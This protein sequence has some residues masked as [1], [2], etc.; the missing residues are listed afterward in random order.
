MED[1]LVLH[2]GLREDA[3]RDTL[4][5]WTIGVGYNLSARGPAALET[6]IGRKFTVKDL[7]GRARYSTLHITREEALKALRLD[8]KR[9]TGAVAAAW[10]FYSQLDPVRQK[11]AVDMAF[12]MG[13]KAERFV[14]TIAAIEAG[15]WPAA[16]SHL[17]HSRWAGQVGDGEGGQFDRADRLTRMLLTGEDYT[18]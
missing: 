15:D 5:Y 2:E 11:V 18:A 14:G 17:Y 16:V 6:A 3:Y 1:Q 8:I 13:H 9:V 10:P 4:G 7:Q 12:N